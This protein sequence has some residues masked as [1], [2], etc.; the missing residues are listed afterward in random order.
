MYF[1]ITLICHYF[2]MMSIVSL[3]SNVEIGMFA[4]MLASETT[5]VLE[6]RLKIKSCHNRQNIFTR[7]FIC[8]H[9]FN[10]SKQIK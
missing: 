7:I 2:L 4:K 6:N 10:S 3:V 8:M 9:E 5:I 1:P